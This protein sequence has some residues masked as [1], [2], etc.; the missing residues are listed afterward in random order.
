[1]SMDKWATS[2]FSQLSTKVWV[3]LLT[4]NLNLLQEPTHNLTPSLINTQNRSKTTYGFIMALNSMLQVKTLCHKNM[5]YLW[6]SKKNSRHTHQNLLKPSPVSER[7]SYPLQELCMLFSAHLW[8]R[9][10]WPQI[11]SLWQALDWGLL[12]KILASI[13]MGRA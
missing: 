3:F 12:S 10:F 13:K 1:M 5:D 9:E 6:L 11:Y 7:S 2:K 8:V 4:E